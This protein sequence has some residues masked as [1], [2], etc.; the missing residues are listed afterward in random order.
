MDLH[1]KTIQSIL[2]QE[3]ELIDINIEEPAGVYLLSIESVNNKFV[4]VLIKK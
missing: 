3:S 4:T 2:C 1:G